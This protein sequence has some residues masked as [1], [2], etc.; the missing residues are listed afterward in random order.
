MTYLFSCRRGQRAA[1]D[2]PST[3]LSRLR[4]AS[5]DERMIVATSISVLMT[6][7]LLVPPRSVSGGHG[8]DLQA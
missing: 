8:G 3:I 6:I 5:L 1:V 7:P 4:C 2:G